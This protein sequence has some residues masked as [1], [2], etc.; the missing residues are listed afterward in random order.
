MDYKQIYKNAVYRKK[1]KIYDLFE[2][3][4]CYC[5]KDP[6]IQYGP[7]CTHPHYCW[8]SGES[9]IIQTELTKLEQTKHW[10]GYLDAQDREKYKKL[11]KKRNI[12]IRQQ[13]GKFKRS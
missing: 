13:I 11:I 7:P 2:V 6:E 4:D 9:S 5:C 10:Q 12:Y 1:Q 3:D 8:L